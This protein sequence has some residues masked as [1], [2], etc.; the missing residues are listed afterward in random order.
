MLWLWVSKSEKA[1]V[2]AAFDGLALRGLALRGLRGRPFSEK[3]KGRAL[4]LCFGCRLS[5]LRHRGRHKP[6]VLVPSGG[7]LLSSL[8][9]AYTMLFE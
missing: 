4:P 6:P 8:Y 1:S 7:Y 9:S 3:S 5:A 2:A